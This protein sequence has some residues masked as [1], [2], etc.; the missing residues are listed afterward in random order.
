MKVTMICENALPESTG[1]GPRL[2]QYAIC[3][4]LRQRGHQ[5][6]IV[7]ITS[8]T[9]LDQHTQIAIQ[10]L[11]ARGMQ[12]QPIP[13]AQAS[14]S[15]ISHVLNRFKPDVIFSLGTWGIAWASAYQV[16]TPRVVMLGD[17]EHY[18][19]TY[20]RQLKNPEPLT[21]EEVA[22]MH[23]DGMASKEVYL[24]VLSTC[25]AAFC[26]AKHSVDWFNRQGFNVEYVPMP[27][28]EPAYM[29]WRRRKEDMPQNE[30]PR[31]LQA[32]HLGGIA[33]L[34]SLYYLVD[35]VLPNMDDIDDYDWH[36]CGGDEL[37]S[38][39]VAKFKKYPQIKFRGYVEDIRKEILQADIFLCTT[40]STCGVRTR[41]VEAMAL[42]SCI[43]A[44]SSNGVGQPEFVTGENL[45]MQDSGEGVAQYIR[46][47]GNSPD[48]R[49]EMG[50]AARQTY[51]DSFRTELS[52]GRIVSKMEEITK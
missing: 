3:E 14:P 26:A 45:A 46:W 33:T 16:S 20:R 49:Y 13:Y 50:L 1:G 25:T 23:I 19:P 24:N 21:Y 2:N 10:A 48:E 38:D 37:Q 34:S 28:V 30:K 29:G 8:L 6:Q 36:I 12:V 44:H 39:L 11:N 7:W 18:L 52:A 17:P 41:L 35:E 43:V 42:G 15:L 27:V 9:E 40:S 47:L 5:L 51:E 4:E 32:G 31:I 22:Q